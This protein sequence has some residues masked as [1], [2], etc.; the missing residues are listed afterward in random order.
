[1]E[2][3]EALMQKRLYAE[4]CKEYRAADIGTEIPNGIGGFIDVVRKTKTGYVYYELKAG[5][6]LQTC[7]RKAIGQ[8]LEYS[9]WPTTQPAGELVIVGETSFDNDSR[10]YLETLK[11]RFR[12]PLQYR[13]V[14]CPRV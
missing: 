14:E 1:M 7:I 3:R 5:R 2:L 6:L 8:L 10:A 9:L 4:L 12:L 11:S 13:Q